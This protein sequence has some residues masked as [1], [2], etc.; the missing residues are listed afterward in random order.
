MQ[1]K[2]CVRKIATIEGLSSDLNKQNAYKYVDDKNVNSNH[3]KIS[4]ITRKRKSISMAESTMPKAYKNNY[5]S[6]LDNEI[7][8]DEEVIKNFQQH[9]QS[10]NKPVSNL[11]EPK[12]SGVHS[13]LNAPASAVAAHSSSVKENNKSKND[14]LSRQNNNKDIPP[15][16][17]FD[18]EAKLII[19]L[20]KDGLKI[21]EFKIKEFR[22]NKIA[23]YLSNLDDYKRVR[24]HLEKANAKFF[25]YTPK[26]LKTKT[27]LLKGLNGNTDPKEILD[28]LSSFQKES[29]KIL[30]I[31][32]FHTKRSKENNTILPIFMVQISADSNANE[33]KAIKYVQYRCI[34]WETLRKPE[35]SQCRNCQSL[36]HSSANC[37]LSPRCVKC[38]DPH[39]SENCPLSN[40]PPI[41][42]DKLYCVLCKKNGHPA[43]YRGCE[44]YKELLNKIKNR[45]QNLNLNK[46]Q[47]SVYVNPNI[48]FADVTRENFT[49]QNENNSFLVEIRNSMLA[50]SKQIMNLQKQLDIQAAR[51]DAICNIVDSV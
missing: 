24:G 50:L 31:E 45:K 26:C 17:V 12:S 39:R 46:K 8:C 10:N 40:Q 32:Q 51:M 4:D 49:S 7:E 5:Y 18:I 37:H 14:N 47:A 33:L 29:L 19:K 30:K 1:N 38:S 13:N 9:V 42:K 25:S 16:N 34:K 36:F 27:Y 20:V 44:R 35:I 23:I 3:S 22:H 28:E 48:S 11:R 6:I 43:S 15:I 2:K 41:E 21:S